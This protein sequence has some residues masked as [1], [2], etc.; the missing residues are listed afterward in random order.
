MDNKIFNVNGKTKK[1]LSLAL[2]TLLTDEYDKE[3]G[4]EGFVFSK[5]KG[6]VLTWFIDKNITPFSIKMGKTQK[7]YYQELTEIL[8]EWLQTDEASTV[9]CKAWDSNHDHDGSNDKGWRLYVEEWGKIK[10]FDYSI[11]AF[12]PC[13]LWYGK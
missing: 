10:E 4:V 2:K 8:W 1:Q 13:Y 3:T 7:I 11:C 6:L 12:K 5:E 9:A